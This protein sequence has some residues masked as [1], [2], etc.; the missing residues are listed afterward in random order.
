[1]QKMNVWKQRSNYAIIALQRKD[2]WQVRDEECSL[3]LTSMMAGSKMYDRGDRQE[4]TEF[5]VEQRFSDILRWVQA[6]TSEESSF[7]CLHC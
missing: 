3:R 7:H 4:V 5:N 1:M 2:M 6:G